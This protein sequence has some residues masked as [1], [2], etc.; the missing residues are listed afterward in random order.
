[1]LIP[2][3]NHASRRERTASESRRDD[4]FMLSALLGSVD[5]GVLMFG[6]G[7]ELRAAND[8]FA[9]MLHISPERLRKLCSFEAL[10]GELAGRAADPENMS[11][12]WRERFAASEELWDELELVRPERKILERFA[13]PM[14]GAQGER[15]GWIETYRDVTSQRLI[16]A[17]LFHTERMAALGQLVSGVAHELNNPLTSILGYAQLMVRRR[18]GPAREADARLILS[19]VERASRITRNLLSFAREKLERVRVSVND[20]VERTLALRSHELAEQNIL[21]D[22]NLEPRLPA[23]LADASQL[24]QVLLNLIVNAEHAIR[25]HAR[26]RKPRKRYGCIWVRTRRISCERVMIEVIDDGP[27]I[28]ADVAQRIFDPFFTTKPAGMGTG[29]GLSIASGIV[30]EHGGQISV[31][32]V[33]GRGAAFRIEL[34]AADAAGGAIT[35]LNGH[36][37]RGRTRAARAIESHYFRAPSFAATHYFEPAG[38]SNGDGPAN[39]ECGSEGRESEAV[40]AA[41]GRQR[42]ETPFSIRQRILVVEDEPTVAGLIADVL[43]Q[44]GYIVDTVL[45]SREGLELTRTQ[46]YDLVICD[47]RMPH[48]DG[49]GFYGELVR[50]ESSLTNRLLFVTGDAVALHT[51]EFLKQSGSA[52]LAKPFLVEELKQVVEQTLAEARRQE[53]TAIGPDQNEPG[54]ARWRTRTTLTPGRTE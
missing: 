34:P 33:L 20:V 24:Q 54:V 37:T 49:R 2:E 53:H 35:T 12:R 41:P 48:L 21:V 15:V 42:A 4:G 50:Q 47:L 22:V 27:G 8:R 26:L 17:R 31:E 30:Q 52:H 36:D 6:G 7:G 44:E 25:L 46:G 3:H 5:C 40:A 45:D 19:E 23:T 9:Q 10:A 16:E 51:S 13:G 1:M 28:A 32:N 39:E 38:D 29:L 14:R 43:S 11:A 18:G